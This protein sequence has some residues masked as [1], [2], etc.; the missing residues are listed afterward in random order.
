LELASQPWFEGWLR[1]LMGYGEPGQWILSL[2][3]YGYDWNTTTKKTTTISFAD[4]MARGQR[5]GG[6][7]VTSSAPDLNPTLCYDSEGESHE[8]WFL[9][10]STFANQLHALER[11]GCAGVLTFR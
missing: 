11:E 2:G 4:A 6:E 1:T 5:S 9:D 10:A 8:V 7:P 3:V